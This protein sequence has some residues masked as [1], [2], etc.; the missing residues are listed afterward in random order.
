LFDPRNPVAPGPRIAAGYSSHL[1]TSIVSLPDA[2]PL[3]NDEHMLLKYLKE[4]GY[5]PTKFEDRLRHCFWL[6]YENSLARAKP[7]QMSNIHSLICDE[8]TFKRYIQKPQAA[9]YFLCKPL[10][11]KEHVASLLQSGMRQL[12]KILDLPDLDSKGKP[13]VKLLELKT[14]ITAMMDMRL[15]GAPTQNIKQLNV[16]V[17]A[18][19]AKPAITQQALKQGDMTAI[20]KRLA[21]LEMERKQLEGRVVEPVPVPVKK[22]EPEAVEIEFEPTE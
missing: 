12:E 9:V 3:I 20:H 11:Y 17:D 14:K 21:E 10:A 5:I 7:M 19:P 13:N 15:H 1:L 4:L 2:L 16:N 18:T 22:K 6:E 8:K